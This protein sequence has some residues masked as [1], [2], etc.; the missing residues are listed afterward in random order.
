MAWPPPC[1]NQAYFFLSGYD[2][3]CT[4]PRGRFGYLSLQH[5]FR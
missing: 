5:Q 3:S 2:P 4:D 1:S